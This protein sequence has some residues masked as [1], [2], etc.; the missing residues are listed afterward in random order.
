MDFMKAIDNLKDQKLWPKLPAFFHCMVGPRR[1]G[2]Q[3]D[4]IDLKTVLTSFFIP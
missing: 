3:S 2:K 1:R 4:G